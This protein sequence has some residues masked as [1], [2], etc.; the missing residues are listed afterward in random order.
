MP[1]RGHLNQGSNSQPPGHESD[2]LSQPGGKLQNNVNKSEY[3]SGKAMIILHSTSPQCVLSVFE[4]S[5]LEVVAQTNIQRK[6]LKIKRPFFEKCN[7]IFDLD[8]DDMTLTSLLYVGS[9]WIGNIIVLV[10]L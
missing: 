3:K 8:L 7:L 6:N 4:V 5:S 1:E 9:L 10:Y 2:T